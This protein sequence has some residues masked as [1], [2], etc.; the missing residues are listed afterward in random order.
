MANEKILQGVEIKD[1]NPNYIDPHRRGYGKFRPDGLVIQRNTYKEG[2]KEK[3]NYLPPYDENTQYAKIL[4]FAETDMYVLWCFEI[5]D[6][7][8][9]EDEEP[10]EE[11]PIETTTDATKSA[12]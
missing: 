8:T 12:N 10:L 11:E 4:G 2:F 3:H 5:C 7:P 9:Y 1:Y 6:Y